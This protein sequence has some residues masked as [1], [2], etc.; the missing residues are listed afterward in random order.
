MQLL[1]ALGRPQLPLA[2]RACPLRWDGGWARQ[3]QACA[4]GI[5]QAA[6]ACAIS[7]WCTVALVAL[8]ATPS[9]TAAPTP[10]HPELGARNPSPGRTQQCEIEE[11][12]TGFA[13]SWKSALPGCRHRQ[14]RRRCHQPAAPPPAAH[15]FSARS[16]S[17]QRAEPSRRNGWLTSSL[18]PPLHTLGTTSRQGGRVPAVELAGC[19][20]HHAR[21]LVP[22]RQQATRASQLLF[23]RQTLLGASLHTQGQSPARTGLAGFCSRPA[24]TVLGH[25]DISMST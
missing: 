4:A 9:R 22:W 15:N 24:L 5:S 6:V 16:A 3:P 18:R 23:V 2:C 8:P 20:Q 10:P 13:V 12:A 14:R 1:P 17:W 25:I 11:A 21:L 19:R 7:I